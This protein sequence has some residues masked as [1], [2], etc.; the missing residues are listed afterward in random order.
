MSFGCRLPAGLRT[1]H[2]LAP[3]RRPHGR[4][5]SLR[6]PP[7]AIGFTLLEVLVALAIFALAAVV[8]GATYLNTLNAYEAATRR[9][10]NDENLRF[11]RAAVLT[12]ASRDKAEEGGELDLGGNRRAHW[13]AEISPTNTVDLFSVTWTCEITDPARPEPFRATQTFLLLRPT[14]SD[15]VK[16]SALLDQVKGRILQIQGEAP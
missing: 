3:E 7:A 1:G 16:R 5:S 6:A 15:P 4:L 13:Q 14:W 11:V 10:A 8:F 12:E 2:G 9:N